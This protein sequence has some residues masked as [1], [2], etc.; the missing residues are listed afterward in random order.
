MKCL[1]LTNFANIDHPVLIKTHVSVLLYAVRETQEKLVVKCN[2]LFSFGIFCVVIRSHYSKILYSSQHF[3]ENNMIHTETRGKMPHLYVHT[4]STLQSIM[5]IFLSFVQ[6][7]RDYK[8][9]NTRSS[10]CVSVA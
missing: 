3:L 2:A 9:S 7:S 6:S 10:L 1:V 4:V 5:C 8:L